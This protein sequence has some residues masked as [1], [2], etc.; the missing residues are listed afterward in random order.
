MRFPRVSLTQAANFSHYLHLP[1]REQGCPYMAC[2]ELYLPMSLN[3]LYKIFWSALQ[4]CTAKTILEMFA[5]VSSA[6][7]KGIKTITF[8]FQSALSV[9]LTVYKI[10]MC[11]RACVVKHIK[12]LAAG[13]TGQEHIALS[14]SFRPSLCLS[15]CLLVLCCCCVFLLFCLLCFVCYF[16]FEILPASFILSCNYWLFQSTVLLSGIHISWIR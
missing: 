8:C 10:H 14:M 15:V 3:Y 5:F 6:A 4:Y 1:K 12:S 16:F 13:F 7:E 9:L 11:V 2:C